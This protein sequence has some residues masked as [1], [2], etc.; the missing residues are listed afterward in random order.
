[1]LYSKLYGM[2]SAAIA[3]LHLAFLNTGEE[4]RCH[5]YFQ[6]ITR[7]QINYAFGSSLRLHQLILQGSYSNASV[8]HA[9]IAL[10]SLSEHVQ[11]HKTSTRHHNTGG[12]LCLQYADTQ[13]LKGISE[14]RTEMTAQAHQ[15]PEMVLVSCVLL[16]LFDFLRGEEAGG[17]IHL[18]AGIDILKRCFGSEL[19]AIP[20]TWTTSSQ[21]ANLLVRD[22]ALTF[23][24][25]DLH[26][27]IWL[28]RPCFHTTPMIYQKMV[29]ADSFVLG[30]S[31]TLDDIADNLNCQIMR[32]HS[33]HHANAAV[34]QITEASYDTFPIVAE[35][36][37][38]LAELQRW[39]AFLTWYLS[40]TLSPT[41]ED[42]RFR[43]ALL[44]MNYHSLLATITS[45]F[46]HISPY[47]IQSF[48]QSV[49]RIIANAKTIVGPD[50][51]AS[52]HDRLLRAVAMNCQ[53]PEPHNMPP[54]AFVPGAIQPLYLAAIKSPNL[55]ES[56]DAIG[57]LE[58]RPWKEGAWDSVIMAKLARK[59]LQERCALLEEMD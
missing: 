12:Q 27:G 5:E 28:G 9:V 40:N 22:F 36:D 55:E 48:T 30:M 26:A 44:W 38:F 21:E 56:E 46:D 35:K 32:A 54:F 57:L 11:Q 15:S 3:D 7:R 14:L 37:R 4:R 53:E 10:G 8:K 47:S 34:Y 58:G 1:M 2:S 24:V 41:S 19:G 52:Y 31:P 49:S 45:F 6:N 50:K 16:S 42:E 51:P 17:R 18:A 43:I 29:L 13:Y 20:D 23:S 39:P 33:F 25:M 59:E